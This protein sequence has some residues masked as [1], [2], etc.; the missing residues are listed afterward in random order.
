MTARFKNM[1]KTISNAALNHAA[2]AEFKHLELSV[3]PAFGPS[4]LA[5]VAAMVG[6][7][8]EV[9]GTLNLLIRSATLTSVEAASAALNANN[10]GTT[11]RIHRLAIVVPIHHARAMA[12]ALK[13]LG[14]NVVQIFV[15]DEISQARCWLGEVTPVALPA[16]TASVIQFD[17][18]AFDGSRRRCALPLSSNRG[19]AGDNRIQHHSGG[20]RPKRARC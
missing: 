17:A 20:Q 4:H 14:A 13:P 18:L 2:V 1:S 8:C 12:E 15:E 3:G 7:H 10:I 16:P 9:H 6:R 19:G 11:A 5:A